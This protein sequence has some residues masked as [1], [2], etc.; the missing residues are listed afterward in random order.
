MDIFTILAL[1]FQIHLLLS[2]RECFGRRY[3]LTC[4]PIARQS[5]RKIF[6]SVRLVLTCL[7]KAP[8]SQAISTCLSLNKYLLVVTEMGILERTSKYQKCIKKTNKIPDYA[9]EYKNEYLFIRGI[10]KVCEDFVEI[11]GREEIFKSDQADTLMRY[12]NKFLKAQQLDY[13]ND[14][15]EI[16]F[17]YEDV[18]SIESL[19]LQLDDYRSLYHGEY[20]YEFV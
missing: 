15:S 6:A 9:R 13:L 3:L 14:T 2:Q 5:A 18:K 10:N 17:K 16:N 7:D 11:L 4:R 1:L 19:E 8:H 12:F 20:S